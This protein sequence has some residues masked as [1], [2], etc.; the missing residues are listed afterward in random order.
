MRNSDANIRQRRAQLI[1]ILQQDPNRDL[2]HL[3]SDL[4][5]SE[6]T[7]RR[8]LKFLEKENSLS[9]RYQ[10]ID[11]NFVK[12]ILPEFDSDTLFSTN[13]EEKEAIARA[14]ASLLL[15][16]DVVYINSSST[17]LRLIKHIKSDY[18]TV[19]TNNA[20]SLF[21]ERN[22]TLKL[23]LVGGEISQ[24]NHNTYAKVRTTGNYAL[25]TIKDIMANVCILGISGISSDK[26]LSSASAYETAINKEMI[27][28]CLG[29]TIVV[30]DNRKIGFTHN[31]IFAKPDKVDCLITDS[32][33][34]E[35]ELKKLKDLGIDV[36][37]V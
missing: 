14:A 23:I 1:K 26:G 37:V 12:N 22:P 36:L 34:D 9:T 18:V 33:A 20:L 28:S 8:D 19:V 16:G 5:V 13:I 30:A 17:A 10:K 27:N 2:P 35:A 29:K 7:I 15:P 11:G 24:D 25:A 32:Q 21:E 6:A 31:Y 4:K 3:A